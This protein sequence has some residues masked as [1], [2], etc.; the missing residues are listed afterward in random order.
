MYCVCHRWA[1]SFEELLLDDPRTNTPLHL[2]LAPS[3]GATWVPHPADD[4]PW[5]PPDLQQAGGGNTGD[6][7]GSKNGSR[8]GSKITG[9]IV[10]VT[11][12]EDGKPR[13][14]H[15]PSLEMVCPGVVAVSPKQRKHITLYS[16]LTT[17]PEPDVEA[18]VS[19]VEAMPML[20][21]PC[22]RLAFACSPVSYCVVLIGRI[23]TQQN[24]GLRDGGTTGWIREGR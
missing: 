18:M 22:V 15:C 20:R 5:D 8:N 24:V 2:P 9:S 16:R 4:W 7:N 21:D 1:G 23:T 10:S 11:H 19:S 3:D 12:F 6:N 17:T 14:H 13:P